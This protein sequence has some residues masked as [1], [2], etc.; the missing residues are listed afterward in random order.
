MRTSPSTFDCLACGGYTGREE[1]ISLGSTTVFPEELGLATPAGG[2][3]GLSI[4][5]TVGIKSPPGVP[6]AGLAALAT[7]ISGTDPSTNLPAR[8]S[9][10]GATIFKSRATCDR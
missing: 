8:L 1:E 7:S 10:V 9:G 6:I 4:C 3:G 2:A 5:E